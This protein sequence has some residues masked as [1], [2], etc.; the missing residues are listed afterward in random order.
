M[1]PNHVMDDE[2]DYGGGGGGSALSSSVD[3]YESLNDFMASVCSKDTNVRLDIYYK[4]EE[5][6]KSDESRVDCVDMVKFCDA[7]LA[8]VAS[9][10]FKISI[11]GMTIVQLLVQRLTD[12]LKTHTTESRRS[13]ACC[14]PHSTV[15]FMLLL[16]LH[17]AL[18]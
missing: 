3:C 5:Y 7:I 8:W 12:D 4:L 1:D 15:S 13:F 17:S 6:L 2:D 11:N 16:L 10:N 9:S 14:F 18:L